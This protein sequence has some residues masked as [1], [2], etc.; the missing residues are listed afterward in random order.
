MPKIDI[1]AIEAFTGS[2]YPEPYASEM[3]ERSFKELGDAAGLTQFGVNIAVLQPGARSSLRHWHVEED[4]FVMILSGDVVLVEEDGETPLTAGECAGFKAGV[5]NGHHL[6]N[7][8]DAPATFLAVGTRA[9]NDTCFYSD[10]DLMMR[11]AGGQSRL[12][13]RDGRPAE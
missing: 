3:G 8:S 4:E 5:E 7:R 9:W 6:I 13:R 12:A 11:T 1:D 2:R 10:V